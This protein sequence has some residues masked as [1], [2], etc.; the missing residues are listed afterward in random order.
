M[1]ASLRNNTSPDAVR[2]PLSTQALLPSHCG[3]DGP[4]PTHARPRPAQKCPWH[5]RR[6]GCRNPVWPQGSATNAESVGGA[7]IQDGLGLQMN[8]EGVRHEARGAGMSCTSKGSGFA[9]INRYSNGNSPSAMKVLMLEVGRHGGQDADWLAR[10]FGPRC[11]SPLPAC[12]ASEGICRSPPCPAQAAQTTPPPRH[13]QQI[14]CHNR[15][16]ACT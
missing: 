10:P 9:L 3:L 16:M 14:I 4:R 7:S 8:G 1:W 5:P 12:P 15:S 6:W 2:S 13:G 11:G